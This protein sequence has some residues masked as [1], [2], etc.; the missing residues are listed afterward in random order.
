MIHIA[1]HPDIQGGYHLHL[2]ASPHPNHP[3]L[4]SRQN[5]SLAAVLERRALNFKFS[6]TFPLNGMARQMGRKKERK[7]EWEKVP[8]EGWS[9]GPRGRLSRGGIRSAEA[10][11]ISWHHYL[12]ALEIYANTISGWTKW[13]KRLQKNSYMF[14]HVF[15][16]P[17]ALNMYVC[18]SASALLVDGWMDGWLGGFSN[19]YLA[20]LV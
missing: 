18:M 7:K 9:L 15:F 1:L 8:V 12:H 19:E 20:V 11:I 17:P 16:C 5:V 14:I 4:I 13:F 2:S 10:A 6:Y 3:A